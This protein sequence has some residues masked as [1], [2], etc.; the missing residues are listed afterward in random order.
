MVDKYYTS[1][2]VFWQCC[3]LLRVFHNYCMNHWI[4]PHVHHI[5]KISVLRLHCVILCVQCCQLEEFCDIFENMIWHSALVSTIF[6]FYFFCYLKYL[7]WNTE[8]FSIKSGYITSV[9]LY[10]LKLWWIPAIKPFS[11]LDYLRKPNRRERKN[12]ARSYSCKANRTTTTY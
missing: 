4:K 6:Q 11:R 8:H 2:T 9:C 5:F 10:P 1:Y 3:Q 12:Q 7:W